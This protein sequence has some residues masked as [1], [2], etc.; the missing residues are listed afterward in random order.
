MRDVRGM[1][2][3]DDMGRVSVSWAKVQARRSRLVMRYPSSKVIAIIEKLDHV[4]DMAFANFDRL[5]E[6]PGLDLFG[7]DHN[8]EYDDDDEEEE[9]WEEAEN[10]V[11]DLLVVIEEE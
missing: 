6:M 1:G 10:E 4:E 7:F 9:G 8:A 3:N 5:F 2:V 11:E